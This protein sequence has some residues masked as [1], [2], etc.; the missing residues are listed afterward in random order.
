M[1]EV[2]ISQMESAG[3]SV[4]HLGSLWKRW[5]KE[6]FG[7]E[8]ALTAKEFGQLKMLKR[9]LRIATGHVISRTLKNWT[10]FCLKAKEDH[11]LPCVPAT[12]HIGFLLAHYDTAVNLM[13]DIAKNNEPKAPGDLYFIELIDDLIAQQKKEL[14]AEIAAQQASDS[15]SAQSTSWVTE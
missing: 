4:V 12:P 13:H 1:A 3:P 15:S 14:A 8:K 6:G 7:V 11:G 5:V 2:G 10:R 9:R